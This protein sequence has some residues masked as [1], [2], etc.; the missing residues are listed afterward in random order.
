[1]N[2]LLLDPCRAREIYRVIQPFY[3]MNPDPGVEKPTPDEQWQVNRLWDVMPGS[4]SF[5][6]AVL[7]IANGRTA[8]W[9][10]LN[11]TH[12]L[13]Q[14]AADIAAAGGSPYWNDAALLADGDGY[15]T[16]RYCSADEGMVEIHMRRADG[17]RIAPIRG[18]CFVAEAEA[19]VLPFDAPVATVAAAVIAAQWVAQAAEP[20]WP[21]SFY[22]GWP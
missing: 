6:D 2:A 15:A 18:G 11:H 4:T 5:A 13:V 21:R 1:M 19:I 9:L 12:V 8:R 10:P 7:R 3:F 22:G 20:R 17:L 16:L 14:R